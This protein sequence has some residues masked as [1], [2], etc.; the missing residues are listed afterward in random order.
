LPEMI[1]DNIKKT[2]ILFGLLSFLL[3]ACP[4]EETMIPGT[5]RYISLEGGF[6]GI[7]SKD[8]RRYDPVNLPAPFRKDN[9]PV[10]FRG[11]VLKDRVGFH[12]WGEIFEIEGIVRDEGTQNNTPREGP[13]RR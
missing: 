4:R 6:Y 8:G 10:R 9:L 13:A 11:K 12:M 1:A 2:L 5:I 7:V 3:V